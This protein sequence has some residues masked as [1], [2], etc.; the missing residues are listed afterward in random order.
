MSGTRGYN[1][2]F[3]MPLLVAISF[4]L[5]CSSVRILIQVPATPHFFLLQQSLCKKF[6]ENIFMNSYCT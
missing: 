6:F 2:N 5:R 4:P 1:F 3:H